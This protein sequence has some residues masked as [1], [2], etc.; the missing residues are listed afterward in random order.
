MYCPNCGT[1]HS[2]GAKFC[3][4]CGKQ[5]NAA[6]APAVSAAPMPSTPQPAGS[7]AELTQ[8]EVKQ[9]AK[10]PLF[11]VTV[12]LFTAGLVL[13]MTTNPL[14]LLLD[15]VSPYLIDL[16]GFEAAYALD[17]VMSVLR[18][19]DLF[20]QIIANLPTIL[21]ALGM[22]MIVISAFQASVASIQPGGL[23]LIK[24][25]VTIF[26]VLSIIGTALMIVAAILGLGMLITDLE[27]SPALFALVLIP[28]LA[29]VLVILYNVKLL[30]T[31]KNIRYTATTGYPV[32]EISGLIIFCCYAGGII[33]ILGSLLN[34][35][36]MLSAVSLLLFGVV[37]GQY[38]KRMLYL[39]ND[40]EKDR[41]AQWEAWNQTTQAPA[42]AP[43]A[44][45]A[46]AIE[47]TPV[48][49]SAPAKVEPESTPAPESTPD[50]TQYRD[51]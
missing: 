34:F 32:S 1:Q 29:L 49:V 50:S 30:R 47:A 31:I 21:Y 18:D 27:A 39:I 40:G 2:D 13:S 4:K 26:F 3:P 25:L 35:A 24:V 17:E 20:G 12:I 19:V 5:L 48:Q 43:E 42:P 45:P 16:F 33:S 37:L 46:P 22:W 7:L 41:R 44:T 36:G 38:K 10:G 8:R 23:T 9:M 15:F 51:E 14:V 28:V 6:T 11:L